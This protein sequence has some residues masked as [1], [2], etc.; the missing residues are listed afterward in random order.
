[1]KNKKI[2]YIR[3]EKDNKMWK[4]DFTKKN[5]LKIE[6]QANEKHR[7]IYIFESLFSLKDVDFENFVEKIKENDNIFFMKLNFNTLK[8]YDNKKILLKIK[9][10]QL[11]NCYA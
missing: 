1:M 10:I 8:F 4:F 9:N 7:N 2:I 11:T 5:E 3:N 6:I